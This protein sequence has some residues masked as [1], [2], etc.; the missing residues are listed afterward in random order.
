MESDMFMQKIEAPAVT[1]NLF[2]T[3]K[4]WQGTG[5]SSNAPRAAGEA[6]ARAY[7][8]FIRRKNNAPDLGKPA[9]H[10]ETIG[11]G[12]GAHFYYVGATYGQ[13]LAKP[14]WCSKARAYVGGE[15]EAGAFSVLFP[16]A[17]MMRQGVTLETLDDA[18][19][20]ISS[21]TMPIEPKK[22][23]VVWAGD[24]VRAIVGKVAKPAKARQPRKATP[25]ASQAAPTCDKRRRAIMLALKLR[26]ELR[27]ER[28]ISASRF[29]HIMDL[30]R[31]LHGVG[32]AES[33]E[34]CAALVSASDTPATAPDAILSDLA[35]AA[36][37]MR[38]EGYVAPAP[39][40]VAPDAPPTAI[41]AKRTPAHER[42]IR[43]A[44]AQR[45]EA[46]AAMA[47]YNASG[48]DRRALHKERDDWQG[49]A[50]RLQAKRRRA[51]LKARDLQ[52]RL[53]AEHR[54][55]DRA[56]D[57]RRLAESIAE[58]HLRM[59]EEL[60]RVLA[61]AERRL[62]AAEAENAQLWAEI[63]TLTAPQPVL[64]G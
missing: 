55:V 56:N 41:Q 30:T 63:E 62:A 60:Q 12:R 23:G 7:A 51:V 19:E 2:D 10:S 34:D 49:R 4:G 47:A 50:Q 58:D 24:D 25:T 5:S 36:A 33:R 64:A 3:V 28:A 61:D 46:R 15:Y 18:G 21:Q 14:E 31:D 32:G 57:R 52:T 44:W 35:A 1:C 17:N 8:D 9:M 27:R 29:G 40:P 13:E 22:G 26:A 37:M 6:E 54:L 38:G 16:G 42:A 11:K 39:L 59:R 53:Y 20:V 45:K 43:R 48:D